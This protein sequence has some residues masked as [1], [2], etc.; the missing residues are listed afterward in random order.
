MYT[1]AVYIEIRKLPTKKWE[2]FSALD[3]SRLSGTLVLRESTEKPMFLG[4]KTIKK[5]WFLAF[6]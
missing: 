2:F 1:D 5:R 4:L 3:F 6:F